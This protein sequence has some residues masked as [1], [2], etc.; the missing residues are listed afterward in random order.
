MLRNRTKLRVL[1]MEPK[2]G[3]NYSISDLAREFDVTPRAIRFYEEK[4]LLEPVRR[5]NT[6]IFSA[7]DRVKLKLIL[8][9]K[10]LGLS[11]E[12]SRDIIGM[13][14]PQTDNTR[15]LQTLLEKIHQ[16][17]A[18]LEL[19]K[20]EINSMLRDLKNTEAICLDALPDSIR[21]ESETKGSRNKR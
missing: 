17:R 18:M 16:K 9:G 8:R 15:Q 7:A 6:R 4:G 10:R 3:G 12:E 2:S 11:L 19:Q 14:E 1:S 21:I 20:K 5:G 13:Y